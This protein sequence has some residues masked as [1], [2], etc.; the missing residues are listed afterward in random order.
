[1]LGGAHRG[2]VALS[3]QRRTIRLV[4]VILALIAVG[5][6]VFAASSLVRWAAYDDGAAPTF[7]RSR[8]PSLLQPV[9]LVILGVSA[10]GASASLGLGKTVRLPTPARLDEFVDRAESV[11][12]E[13]AERTA[14][15]PA[16]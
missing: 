9:V 14:T 10:A 3:R 2:P 5:L 4:Q 12:I 15:G 7:E 11:A 1:M 13:R 6:L 8:P 16:D